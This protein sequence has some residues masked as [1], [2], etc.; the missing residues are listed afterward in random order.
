MMLLAQ[1][2]FLNQVVYR[3]NRIQPAG[4]CSIG[5]VDH[6]EIA[7]AKGVRVGDEVS[8]K[9]RGVNGQDR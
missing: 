3:Y 6:P 2:S 5:V 9:E 8:I 1:Q 4:V 7:V